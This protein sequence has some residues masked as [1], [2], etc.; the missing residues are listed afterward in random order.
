M[1]GRYKL[2]ASHQSPFPEKRLTRYECE[3]GH[4]IDSTNEEEL[5]KCIDQKVGCWK[6]E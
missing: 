1:R 2:Q 3:L 6:E 5:Q 4:E